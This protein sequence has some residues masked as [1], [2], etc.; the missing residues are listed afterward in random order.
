MPESNAFSL[1]A[2]GCKIAR[3]CTGTPAH[4]TKMLNFVVEKKIHP[5]VQRPVGI[6][7]QAIAGMD[8]G[9][10]EYRYVLVDAKQMKEARVKI[11]SLRI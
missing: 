11:F 8:Q 3:S 6:A 10:A 4:V 9:H 2:S 5:V 1:T 7:N